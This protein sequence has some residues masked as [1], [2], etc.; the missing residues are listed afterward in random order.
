MIGDH[1]V[2][3]MAQKSSAIRANERP[4]PPEPAFDAVGALATGWRTRH[5]GKLTSDGDT[6][7]GAVN[8][9]TVGRV[10]WNTRVSAIELARL[11]RLLPTTA[12][13]AGQLHG[14]PAVFSTV[15]ATIAKTDPR[16]SGQG[17]RRATSDQSP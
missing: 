11:H 14:A 16:T 2:I 12:R 8:G 4:A 1:R 15:P 5:I 9:S 3:T 7:F 6:A 13:S 17:L 10:F